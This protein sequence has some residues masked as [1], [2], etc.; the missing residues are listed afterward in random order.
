MILVLAG[1]KD[2][3]EVAQELG[4]KGYQVL[5]TAVSKYG[6][7]LLQASGAGEVVVKGLTPEDLKG[8]IKEKDISL[9]IDATHPFAQ[10]ISAQA[11]EVTQE[12]NLPYLRFERKRAELPENPLIHK[13]KNI[14]EAA[15]KAVALGETIFLTTGS[16]NLATFLALRKE[17]QPRIVA[18]VLP[19]PGVLE[20][21]FALGL[22][23]RDIIA[24][25]GPFSKELNKALFKQY[26]AQV[27]VSKESGET[28]GTDSK[29]EAALELS[30]PLV[31]VER[32]QLTYPL[33]VESVRQI[34]VFLQ[35]WEVS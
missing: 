29:I 10:Q 13:V 23:P 1:T 33:L 16:K 3:R 7:E 25:Q 24:L 18:R 26:G 30:I 28:G 21:C 14:E 6:G 20:K 34:E 19:D 22:N 12:L 32:P 5:A 8:I 31:I 15:R 9:V 2:G 11:M 17:G 27:I 4:Q 35:K